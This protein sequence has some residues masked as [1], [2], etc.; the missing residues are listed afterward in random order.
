MPDLS[1]ALHFFD[2][3]LQSDPGYDMGLYGRGLVLEALGNTAA[4]RE[5]YARLLASPSNTLDVREI[6][7]R[8]ERLPK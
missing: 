7:S 8:L 2:R 3:S 1:R 5:A 6:R 4:A